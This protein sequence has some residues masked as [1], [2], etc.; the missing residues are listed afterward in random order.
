MTASVF[1]TCVRNARVCASM[2]LVLAVAAGCTKVG[3]DFEL[4]AAPQEDAWL[5]EGDPKVSTAAPADANWWQVFGDP[6][7]DELI[8]RAYA[9]NL[10]LQTAGLRVL[11]ARARL[12]IAI[13]DQYPQAQEVGTDFGYNTGSIRTAGV[14]TAFNGA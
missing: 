8:T 2:V 4:P 9:Q 11:E 10:T 6:V 14:E 1:T 7:L 5:E 12:G 3:P 13:G